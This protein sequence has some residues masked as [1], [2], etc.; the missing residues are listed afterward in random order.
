MS[1]GPSQTPTGELETRRVMNPS[2]ID[3]ASVE[4]MVSNTCIADAWK[5]VKSNKGASGVDNISI[6]QFPKWGRPKWKIIK[7]QVKTG[8]YQPTPALRVEIP[9]ESGGIRLLGLFE[10]SLLLTLRAS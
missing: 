2:P 10:A 3:L 5:K 8:S 1:F 7:N 6:E 9:K 4:Y